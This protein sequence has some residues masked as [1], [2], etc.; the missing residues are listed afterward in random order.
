M[1][2]KAHLAFPGFSQ[3]GG[4]PGTAGLGETA[5]LIFCFLLMFLFLW[6]HRTAGRVF[7]PQPGLEPVPLQQCSVLTVDPL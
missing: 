4:A 5:T 3:P 7:T 2:M 6:P 1:K